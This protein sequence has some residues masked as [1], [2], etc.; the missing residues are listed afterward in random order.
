MTR[1]SRQKLVDRL[2]VVLGNSEL[3][4]C[5]VHI[6][7]HTD[8]LVLSPWGRSTVHMRSGIKQG[9]IES[10]AIF[11]AIMQWVI[12]QAAAANG[13]GR[14]QG[15]DGLGIEQASYM[16]DAVLWTSGVWGRGRS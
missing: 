1:V 7:Q 15:F 16:D 10:P 9:A 14:E 2:T 8:A 12:T 5:W 11:T 4:H 6:L 13:W 3:L